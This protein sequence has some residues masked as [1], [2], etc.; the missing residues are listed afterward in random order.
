MWGNNYIFLHHL[1]MGPSSF[2]H[3]FS[4]EMG[5]ISPPCGCCAWSAFLWV[6]FG[7]GPG[8]DVGL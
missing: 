7:A 5:L 2:S 1:V 6:L 3:R 4:Q 8:M